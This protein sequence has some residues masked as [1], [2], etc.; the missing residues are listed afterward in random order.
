[1][2]LHAGPKSGHGTTGTDNTST[3]DNTTSDQSQFGQGQTDSYGTGTGTGTGTTD[4]T[5]TG[6]GYGDSGY[7]GDGN[8]TTEP[9]YDAEQM[10]VHFGPSLPS[11][12]FTFIVR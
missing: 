12:H 2:W 3:F 1:M 7:G 11:P 10:G 5:S 9:G 6:G 4:T 8:R